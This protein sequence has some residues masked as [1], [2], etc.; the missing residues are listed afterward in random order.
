MG[1]SAPKAPKFFFDPL[2]TR[3]NGIFFSLRGRGSIARFWPGLFRG[4][5]TSGGFPST[6]GEGQKIRKT[7]FPRRQRHHDK[8][9]SAFYEI[10]G[11]F[12][13]KNA[14][15]SDFWGVAGRYISKISKKNPFFGE[16]IHLPTSKNFLVALLDV[17]RKLSLKNAIK[18]EI[19]GT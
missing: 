6:S 8:F 16:Q 1:F 18:S 2:S 4:L 10:F 11:K 13:N 5:T 14:I 19:M 17:S 12:V 3:Y 9:L 15:K 7:G